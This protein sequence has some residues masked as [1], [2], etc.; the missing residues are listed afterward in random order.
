MPPNGTPADVLHPEENDSSM[1][2]RCLH[3]TGN[4][5]TNQPPLEKC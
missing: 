2:T 1:R 4:Y 5:E 3:L